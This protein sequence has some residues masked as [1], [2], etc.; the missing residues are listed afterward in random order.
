MARQLVDAPLC[1]GNLNTSC[2]QIWGPS[3]VLMGDA[4]HSMWPTLGQGVNAALEDAA[5]LNR[6]LKGCRV[7]LAPGLGLGN[8]PVA[9]RVLTRVH[10]CPTSFL[11]SNQARSLCTG[12]P[13]LP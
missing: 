4:A 8:C 6:V 13:R 10:Y 9:V 11:G 2:S 1:H 5:V 12:R 3:A 7:S